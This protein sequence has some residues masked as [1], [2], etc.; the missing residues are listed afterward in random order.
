MWWGRHYVT[1]QRSSTLYIRGRSHKFH[2]SRHITPSQG[3]PAEETIFW[4][5]SSLEENLRILFIFRSFEKKNFPFLFLSSFFRHDFVSKGRR[6]SCAVCSHTHNTR[7]LQ[8]LHINH[9]ATSAP[10]YLYCYQF[11][12]KIIT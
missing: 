12:D 3:R 5:S 10:L 9:Q 6:S 8:P 1:S 11:N 2:F 7:I 4:H